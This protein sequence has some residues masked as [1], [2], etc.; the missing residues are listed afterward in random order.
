MAAQVQAAAAFGCTVDELATLLAI[1]PTTIFRNKTVFEEALEK[2]RIISNSRIKRSL[3]ENGVAGSLGH[4][5]M[6]LK[7][8]GG[9]RETTAAEISGPG[10]GPIQSQTTLMTDDEISSRLQTLV[11]R[12]LGVMAH[13]SDVA[14]DDDTPDRV[15]STAQGISQPIPEAE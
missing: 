14:L 9:W 1:D 15:D 6:W 2:G 10:G 5:T 3:F 11:E 8:V 4:A 12:S 7:V 13:A